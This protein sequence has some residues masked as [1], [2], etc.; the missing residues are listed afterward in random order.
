MRGDQE[1]DEWAADALNDAD[2][3]L[4][5]ERERDARYAHPTNWVTRQQM[6]SLFASE[7]M[8]FEQNQQERGRLRWVAELADTR[9]R[10]AEAAAEDAA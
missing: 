1:R 4:A 2:D 6:I 8:A 9:Q 5:W 7:R 10:T 3:V